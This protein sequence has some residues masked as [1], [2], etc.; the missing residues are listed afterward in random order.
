METPILFQAGLAEAILSNSSVKQE[1]FDNTR[2][3]FVEFGKQL[4]TLYLQ[5]QEQI[6]KKGKG[7]KLHF[8]ESGAFEMS[9]RF[10]GDVLVFNMHSNVFTF[11]EN[12]VI[13]SLDYTRKDCNNC[14]C[15]LIEIYNF[16][17]DSLEFQRLNDAGYLVCRIFVNRESHFL[18]EGERPVIDLNKGF[19]EGVLS[20]ELISAIIQR[21]IE[22]AL[23]FDLWAP[24]L[25][26]V[27]EISVLEKLQQNGVAMHRTSKRLGFVMS[28]QKEDQA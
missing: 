12:H 23:E 19:A 28:Y 17:S 15:G 26:E 14:Y 18:I 5:L 3:V 13:H 4:R 16:L 24:P 2:S 8:E 25:Q 27:R 22:H 6:G 1:V 20:P 10:A 9:F 11:E 21:S 7:V